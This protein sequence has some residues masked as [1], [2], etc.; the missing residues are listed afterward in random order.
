MYTIK[1]IIRRRLRDFRSGLEMKTLPYSARDM[2]STP[3]QGAKMPHDLWPQNENMKQKQQCKK[4]NKV[5]KITIHIKK[6]LKKQQTRMVKLII[7]GLQ[8]M[9]YG[10]LTIMDIS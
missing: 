3:G 10:Q 4:F 2:G 6:S 5:L 7:S 9:K 8:N 1:E